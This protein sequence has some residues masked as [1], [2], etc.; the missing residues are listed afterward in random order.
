[1]ACLYDYSL[2]CFI[3][4][5]VVPLKGKTQSGKPQLLAIIPSGAF[6]GGVISFIL[7]PSELVKVREN[8]KLDISL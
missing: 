8:Q 4:I 3:L 1:M 5:F 7:C 2:P 6:A